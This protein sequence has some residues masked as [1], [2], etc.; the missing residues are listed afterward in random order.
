MDYKKIS[1]SVFETFKYCCA[2]YGIY[3]IWILLH[4]M[5]SHLYIRFCVPFTF[6]GF[7]LSPIIMANPY[8]VALRWIIY[9]AGNTIHTMWMTISAFI[10]NKLLNQAIN[11]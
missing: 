3:M 9:N 2:A 5:A 6:Y 4:F 7:L 11:T 1:Y 8:C 10:V